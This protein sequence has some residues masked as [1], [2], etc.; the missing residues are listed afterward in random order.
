[1]F[2]QPGNS[3]AV[4][5]ALLSGHALVVPPEGREIPDEFVAEAMNAG[6]VPAEPPGKRR[7]RKKAGDDRPGG[8]EPQTGEPEGDGGA[9]EEGGGE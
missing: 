9:T 4:H 6:C 1:M 7:G 5:V 3:K 8:E 2:V